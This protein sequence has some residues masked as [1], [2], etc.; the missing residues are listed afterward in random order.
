MLTYHQWG[1]ISLQSMIS[2]FLSY[3]RYWCGVAT[4]RGP[5]ASWSS[6]RPQWWWTPS[7]RSCK[8]PG[9]ARMEVTVP[10]QHILN[11]S[12]SL[13][14]QAYAVV[15]PCEE[16]WKFISNQWKKKMLLLEDH[17]FCT[18][19]ILAFGH[20]RC[21]RHVCR[22]WLCVCVCVHQPWACPQH[23][24]SPI[25]ARFHKFVPEVQN[26]LV[27]IPIDLEGGGGQLTVTCKVKFNLK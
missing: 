23:Y 26:T 7:K 2:I 15:L 3:Q 22:V 1:P 18:M 16:A 10:K 19:L 27:K 9:V 13:G 24:L 4:R 17:I 5:L 25:Q 8:W 20:C 12:Q 6:L 11:P 21:L 14:N